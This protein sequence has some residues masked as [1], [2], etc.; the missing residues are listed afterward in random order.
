MHTLSSLVFFVSLSLQLS[1]SLAVNNTRCRNVPGSSGFPSV[2]QW[3]ALNHSISG[4][5]ASVIPFAKYC[6]NLPSG[7]CT[8]EQWESSVFRDMIPG[9]MNSVRL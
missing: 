8:D 4:R 9:A 6:H 5:L 3:N 1:T 2:A 7:S